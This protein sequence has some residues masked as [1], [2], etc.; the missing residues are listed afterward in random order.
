MTPN[1]APIYRV[2]PFA[3]VADVRA[4]LEFYGLL[5]FAACSVVTP[6]G[7]PRPYWALARTGVAPAG[8]PSDG[9]GPGEFM[10]ALAS[11]PVVPSQQAVLLYMYSSDV[12]ALRAHLLRAGV[13]D[14]G[15]LRG[16]CAA[17]FERRA[18]FALTHPDY[19]PAGE[20]RLHDPDGYVILIGQLA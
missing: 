4:S 13:Q 15:A 5:G 16:V 19:M 10:L 7:D 17:A 1:P 2:V 3:H 20:L 14:G 12:R 8:I 18:L 6:P 11:A 9:N